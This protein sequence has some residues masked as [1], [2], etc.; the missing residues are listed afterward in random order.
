MSC[1]Y[2]LDGH[3]FNSELELDDFLLAKNYLRKEL[4]D[5]VFQVTTH[6]AN[7]MRILEQESQKAKQLE[8]EF[9]YARNHRESGEERDSY[10]FRAPYI[11]VNKFL[12]GFTTE[13]GSLLY[14]EFIPENYW[15]ENDRSQGRFGDWA[16]GQYTDDELELF[17]QTEGW[18]KNNPLKVSDVRQ[19]DRL[20][21]LIENK[22]EHQALI[23]DAMHSVLEFYFTR[24]KNPD[25]TDKLDENGNYIYNKDLLKTD[26]SFKTTFRQMLSREKYNRKDGSNIGF[27]ELMND[28]QFEQALT[29]CKELESNLISKYGSEALFFPEFKITGKVE[30]PRENGIDTLMGIVDLLVIDKNGLPQIIDYKTSIHPRDQ[31]SKAKILGYTY[32]VL[33]YGR[34]LAKAGLDIADSDYLICPIHIADFQYINDDE[35]QYSGFNFT[36]S[37]FENLR[38]QAT[39]ENKNTKLN[40]VIDYPY[41]VEVSTDDLLQNVNDTLTKWFPSYSQYKTYEYEDAKKMCE[42]SNAFEPDETGKLNFIPK[43]SSTGKPIASVDASIANAEDELVKKVMQW[44][45]DRPRFREKLVNNVKKSLKE[46]IEKGTSEGV[47][48]TDKE[49]QDWFQKVMARY[50]NSNWEIKDGEQYKPLE[51]LGIITL[52]NKTTRQY[53]FVRIST[54]NLKRQFNFGKGSNTTLGGAFK[55]DLYFKSNPNSMMMQATYGNIELMESMLAINQMSHVFGNN[56][57]VGEIMVADPQLG[58][59]IQAAS[60]K[61]LLETFN[62]IE[63]C[64]QE[65]I[66]IGNNFKSGKIKMAAKVQIAKTMLSDI[67]QDGNGE[68]YPEAAAFKS[69]K[70]LLDTAVDSDE[71]VEKKIEALEAV[72]RQLRTTDEG[73]SYLKGYTTNQDELMKDHVAL[74]NQC[75]LAIA[76]LKGID[77]RQQLQDHSKWCETLMIHKGGLQGNMLDNPGNLSSET[78]NLVTKLVTEAYQNVRADIQKPAAEMRKLVE[79][80]K[81]E[82][83]FG[84]LTENTVG[85]QSSLYMNMY[86]FKENGDVYYKDPWDENSNLSKAEREFLKY[87]LPIIN[88]NRGYNQVRDR[89][90]YFRIPLCDGSTSVVAAKDGL[91]ASLKDKLKGWSPKEAYRRAK[92]RAE[93]IFSDELQQSH[94]AKKNIDDLFSMTNRFDYG[95]GPH[96]DKII[97][98]GRFELNGETIFLKH[99]FAYSM[100]SRIDE[101]FPMIKASMINLTVQGFNQNEVDSE[102]NLGFQNDLAYLRDYIKNKIKNESIIPEEYRPATEF[103]NKIKQAASKLV[104]G[105]SPVQAIYQTIQGIWQDISLI[106]RKPDG[107]DAFTLSNM[108]QAAKIV[109]SDLKHLGDE[110]TLVEQFNRLYGVNDM[111]MNTYID[112]IKTD[113]NGIFNFNNFLF[114]FASRPDYYNRMTIFVAKMINEG[115][116]EAH[117]INK[118]GILEYDCTKDKRYKAFFDD[119]RS[120]MEEYNKAKMYYIAAAKQFEKENALNADG[121]PFKLDLSAKTKL[122]RAYTNLEAE[123][124]K[125]LGDTLYGYY[126][127]EKKSMIQSTLWGSLFM[128]F[129]TFWSGKKNQYLAT[130]GVKLEGHWTPYTEQDENGNEVRYY[131]QK[132][133]DG[134]ILFNEPPV[135]EGDPNASDEQVVRWEGDW[136]EGIVSTMFTLCGAM[137]NDG[138]RDG[139]RS[140]WYNEDLNL[141]NAYRSNIKQLAYDTTM[142]LIVGNLLAAALAAGYDDLEKDSSDKDFADALKL[143][144]CNIAI[145]SIKN[146]FLDFNFI[147]SIGDPAVSWTPFAFEYFGK[148]VSNI[149]DTVMGDQ[150]FWT[151]VS[152]SNSLFTQFKPVFHTIKANTKD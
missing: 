79:A 16:K 91:L 28:A 26:T 69:C 70:S 97:A 42:D 122:P 61:E 126:S 94:N 111:D 6:Q 124:M 20:R 87:V 23:G 56:A 74:Y 22:W 109:Y 84:W 103:I 18:D 135:K 67:F 34:L 68:A 41:T 85:N 66:S 128:Q 86:D 60:N 106:I 110:P 27:D 35:Y 32:Q 65:K 45:K 13:D 117:S 51:A 5:I 118:D 50:C 98:R 102:G 113:Q 119:D 14:P 12:S 49:G 44:L 152:R 149:Y 132:D 10:K 90:K 30:I 24:V 89:D 146:S 92:E 150:N 8:S 114:K 145:K 3:Q 38:D 125:A 99:A 137:K 120:N 2:L 25:G 136:K 11:G 21:A 139:W 72:I 63:H 133:G 54:Q 80:L 95:E 31:F 78:L 48:F 53:N 59:G 141:R 83:N 64:S 29:C 19:Q 148:Q 100:K 96:R 142:F 55:S 108:L 73:K 81:K 112:K 17:V 37:I 76:E 46:G 134:N 33:T 93:G 43:G 7:T 39:D 15:G 82:K 62:E 121:T 36:S 144:A 40:E 127:H 131:Y 101:V 1:I 107:T 77:F 143:T 105:L 116:Y 57:C 115:A 104:L 47:K 52:F 4:G 129:K 58:V 147:S 75:L 130:G 9:E 88:S 123:S 138:I 151:G 140:M 71:S